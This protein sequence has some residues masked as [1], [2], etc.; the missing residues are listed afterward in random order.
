MAKQY[1]LEL[2]RKTYVDICDDQVDEKAPPTALFMRA[3]D[4]RGDQRIDEPFTM[5]CVLYP[6]STPTIKDTMG[7]ILTNL[8][9]DDV[10]GSIGVVTGVQLDEQT[11][12]PN[13]VKEQ[14]AEKRSSYV[15]NIARKMLVYVWP[16][17]MGLPELRPDQ[18][19]WMNAVYNLTA[20]AAYDTSKQ[21]K[22]WMLDAQVGRVAAGVSQD[23]V[24]V[25]RAI[26]S[27]NVMEAKRRE[28]MSSMLANANLESVTGP[29]E[30]EQPRTNPLLYLPVSE[31]D[32]KTLVA[33][34]AWWWDIF[35]VNPRN[36]ERAY[37]INDKGLPPHL[38]VGS[39]E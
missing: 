25:Y 3:L 34:R 12:D 9:K 29:L 20:T 22:L 32:G 28:A 23:L 16:H 4:W 13:V 24:P 1:Y 30:S 6:G 15:P 11:S 19:L 21:A 2:G 7:R 10:L 36:P 17:K 38:K 14:T 27:G 5:A 26:M 33:H 37:R 8:R 39:S 18:R 35:T 31:D